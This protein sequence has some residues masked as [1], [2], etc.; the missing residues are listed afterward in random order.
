[1]SKAVR[2]PSKIGRRLHSF[3]RD[4]V[5]ELVNLC[6]KAIAAGGTLVLNPE[7]S[8]DEQSTFTPDVEYLVSQLERLAVHGT[9]HHDP[10]GH[11]HDF[12][13]SLSVRNAVRASPER[14]YDNKVNLVSDLI[15]K[16]ETTARR[17]IKKYGL[18][19]QPR[20]KKSAP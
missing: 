14:G 6:K 12:V 3:E 11:I 19:A 13:E 20:T 16:S 7:D 5:M 2:R 17:R 10:E 18:T 8:F 9:L 4:R 15:G 1:M